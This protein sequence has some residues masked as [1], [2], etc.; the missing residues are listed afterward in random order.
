[1]RD[2]HARQG[3][4]TGEERQHAT[5]DPGALMPGY[6]SV[7]GALMPDIADAL[8]EDRHGTLIAIEVTAG[9]KTNSFP[10]G[11]NTWRK[12]IGCRV[13][14]PAVDGKANRA[15]ISLISERFS[16]PAARVTIQSGAL[17]SQKRVL[18]EGIDRNDLL[19]RL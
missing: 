4:N 19:E 10:A 11:Y 5:G 2:R 9:A 14:A 6:I 3:L 8:V 13:T 15:V 16:I 17:S 7:F 18:V 12:T 1:M